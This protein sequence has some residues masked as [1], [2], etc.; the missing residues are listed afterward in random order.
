MSTK[1][2][3]KSDKPIFKQIIDLI[4]HNLYRKSVE[5]YQTDKYCSKYYTYDQLVS[6]MFGQLNHCLSLRE[7]SPGID[8]RL[9]F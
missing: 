6:A 7:I 8:R 3:K 2:G 5:K 9:N 4:P 1:L